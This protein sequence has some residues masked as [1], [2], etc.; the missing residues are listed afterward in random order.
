MPWKPLLF[1]KKGI[2][3]SD[4]RQG[5]GPQPSCAWPTEAKTSRTLESRG[6]GMVDR[7]PGGRQLS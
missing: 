3:G 1:A 2:V 7:K 5:K 6:G 4:I